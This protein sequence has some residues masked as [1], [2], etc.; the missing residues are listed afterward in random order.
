MAHCAGT[1]VYRKEHHCWPWELVYAVVTEDTE[2]VAGIVVSRVGGIVF[3]PLCVSVVK[4]EDREG[5]SGV[6]DLSQVLGDTMELSKPK[7]QVLSSLNLCW[8]CRPCLC[9]LDSYNEGGKKPVPSRG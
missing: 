5:C 7:W 2:R 9:D 3:R 6:S 4:G 1:R 8:E